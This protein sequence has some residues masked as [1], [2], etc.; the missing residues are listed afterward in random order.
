MRALFQY[1]GLVWNLV[2]KDLKLK[3]RDS[4]LGF[5]WSL[6]NPLLFIAVYTLAFKYIMHVQTPNYSLFLLAGVLHWNLFAMALSSSTSCIVSNG[7]LIKKIP[8]PLETLPVASVLFSLTQYFFALIVLL[9]VMFLYFHI[10]PSWPLIALVPMLAFQFVFC[11]GA[12]M[13]LATATVF[14]RDVVHF[15]ELALMLLFWL[16]PVIYRMS[17]VPDDLRRWIL[18]NPFAPFILAYQSILCDS[19][20]PDKGIILATALLAAAALGCGILMFRRFRSDFA[21]EI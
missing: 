10:R 18:L 1:R 13:A 14:Y 5:F 4:M 3:Y 11:V 12:G 19:R 8:F 20:L 9:P 2:S 17:D 7:G 21:E 6:A 16:T 15:V